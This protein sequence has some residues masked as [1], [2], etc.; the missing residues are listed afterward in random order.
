MTQILSQTPGEVALLA[1]ERA[2]FEQDQRDSP[3]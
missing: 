1:A 3:G 2:R